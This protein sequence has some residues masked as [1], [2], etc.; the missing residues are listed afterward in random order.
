MTVKLSLIIF[1]CFTSVLV[2][3][4]N[5]CGYRLM[6]R[7]GTLQL[8]IVVLAG[9]VYLACLLSITSASAFV[10]IAL[11]ALVLLTVVTPLVHFLRSRSAA[12]S[13]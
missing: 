3:L 9:I 2:L 12:K 11:R 10:G 1:S 5:E 6:S 8:A 7:S 13:R 4:L